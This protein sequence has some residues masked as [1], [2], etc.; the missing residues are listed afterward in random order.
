MQR[1]RRPHHY[2]GS[3]RNALVR[4]AATLGEEPVVE[5]VLG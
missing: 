5:S 3:N 1:R 2:I 4:L